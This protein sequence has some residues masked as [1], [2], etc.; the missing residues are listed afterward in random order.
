MD[1]C[2]HE[3]NAS[4]TLNFVRENSQSTNADIANDFRQVVHGDCKATQISK[5]ASTFKSSTRMCA[6]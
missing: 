4:S 3:S 5:R 1:G 2:E 6:P